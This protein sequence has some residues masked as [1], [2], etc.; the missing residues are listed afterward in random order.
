MGNLTPQ[1]M[2]YIHSLKLSLICYLGVWLTLSGCRKDNGQNHT[3]GMSGAR[4]WH[5][6]RHVNLREQLSDSVWV[7]YDTIYNYTDTV[8][9]VQVTDGNTISVWGASYTYASAGAAS[10]YFGSFA[11]YLAYGTGSGIAYYN[12]NDSMVLVNATFSSIHGTD[13][14]LFTTYR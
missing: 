10:V 14:T 6:Y 1:N 7:Q 3:E 4:K 8:F 9:A 5:G 13:T 11:Q 2:K 12:Q